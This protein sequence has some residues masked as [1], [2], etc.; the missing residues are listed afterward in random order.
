V[1][2]GRRYCTPSGPLP[3]PVAAVTAAGLHAPW[4][5]C[6]GLAGSVPLLRFLPDQ[7]AA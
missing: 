1:D 6:G 2:R 5:R 3:P 4:G 7:Y